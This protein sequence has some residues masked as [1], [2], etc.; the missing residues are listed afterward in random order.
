M[1]CVPSVY[2]ILILVWWINHIKINYSTCKW[3]DQCWNTGRAWRMRSV[4]CKCSTS[5][6]P[7]VTAAHAESACVV[8]GLRLAI[9]HPASAVDCDC[10]SGLVSSLVSSLVISVV[11]RRSTRWSHPGGQSGLTSSCK[12]R[13]GRR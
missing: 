3:P 12:A 8:E 5:D 7:P 11:V 1:S 10:A 4:L 9:D 6:R 13:A 2:Q